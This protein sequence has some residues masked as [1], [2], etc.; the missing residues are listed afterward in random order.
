[1]GDKRPRDMTT[2]ELAA[3]PIGPGYTKPVRATYYEGSDILCATIGERVYGF[4]QYADGSW[5]R[6]VFA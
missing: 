6:Q 5:Y 1:M 3:L 2:E 4:G